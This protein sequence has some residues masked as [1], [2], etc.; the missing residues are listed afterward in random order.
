MA[1]PSGRLNSVRLTAAGSRRSRSAKGT[2]VESPPW[3]LITLLLQDCSKCKLQ[4]VQPVGGFVMTTSLVNE[5][6][7]AYLRACAECEQACEACNYNCCV[8]NPGMADCARLCLDCATI[9]AASVT[10]LARGSAWSSQLCQLCAQI[11]EACAAECAKH[12]DPYC[13][14][15]AV[16]CRRCADQC[17]AMMAA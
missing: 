3:L 10:L 2:R 9:C 16:A 5:R 4:Q 13:R 11:C 1:A 17:H 8:N 12:D 14:E 7:Q 6:N 15:C